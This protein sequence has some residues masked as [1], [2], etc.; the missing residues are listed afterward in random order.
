M[1]TY[2]ACVGAHCWCIHAWHPSA[3][4]EAGDLIMAVNQQKVTTTAEF[5][6]AMKAS[7]KSGKALLLVKRG[8]ISQFVVIQFK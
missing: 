2:L 3:G 6:A 1:Q 7:R 4:I 5:N 8:Q